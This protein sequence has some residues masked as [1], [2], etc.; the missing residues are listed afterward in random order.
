MHAHPRPWRGGFIQGC[1]I[2]LAVLVAVLVAA[3][4]VVAFNFKSWMASGTAAVAKAVI[5]ESELPETEKPEIKAIIDQLRDEVKAG[6]VTL[7][8]VSEI[9]EGLPDSP[10]LAAGAALQFVGMYVEPSGL[11]DEEKADGVVT[12]DR[13]AFALS[14]GTIAWDDL[15]EILK[16]IAYKQD[17]SLEFQDP[18]AV[19]DD[20]L[21][22]VIAQAREAA[23]G[24]GVPAEVEKID[25]SDT[26]A[27]YIEEKL[28][29]PLDGSGG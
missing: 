28:G 22:Q 7:E 15:E 16:P 25:L 12:F 6:T 14:E 8:Q 2:A 10:V 1:L 29:R 5:D 4:V 17:D 11:T 3:G 20:E 24:A 21:R 26:F 23:D 18:K 27:A 19:S 13:L 9:F